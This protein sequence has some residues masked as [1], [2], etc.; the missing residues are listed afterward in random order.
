MNI[1]TKSI[2]LLAASTLVLGACSDDD[3][4][5]NTADATTNPTIDA[6]ATVD[7]TTTTPDATPLSGV[8][9]ICAEDGP[10]PLLF[11]KTASCNQGFGFL[12]VLGTDLL[13]YQFLEE[14]C[15]ENINSELSTGN[16]TV[17]DSKIQA[18]ID[19]VNA[20]PCEELDIDN[21]VDTPCQEITVGSLATDAV[22]E[23]DGECA[24]DAYCLAPAKS[25]CGACK[26]RLGAGQ[27]CLADEACTDGKC[28]AAGQCAT[29][30][31]TGGA[32]L[33][34][35]DCSGSLTCD[36]STNTCAVVAPAVGDM[37]V[38]DDACGG[39]QNS[40]YCRFPVF[41]GGGPQLLG[42]CEVLPVVGE[43]CVPL[44]SFGG[45]P[46]CRFV[47]SEW[48]D[49]GTCA[50][51]ASAMLGEACN[52]FPTQSGGAAKCTSGLMCTNGFGAPGTTGTCVEAGQL[53]DTCDFSGDPATSLCHPFY[54]CTMAGVCDLELDV[55]GM[56]PAL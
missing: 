25:S 36:P 48:C 46:G 17:D 44:D 20:T 8:D 43:S 9:A 16:T 54:D 35:E 34:D 7:A 37:C 23:V 49:Q 3:D 55:T 21:L 14:L 15:R 18:C 19:Y 52:I 12:E 42:S 4:N 53:G 32:C 33:G 13:S 38:D 56:C 45:A 27:A 30:I 22:C 24:G 31:G 39:L 26:A 2:G 10:L 6:G 28:N 11:N 29:P 50:A 41:M 1:W 40:L 5:N 51:P 47:N